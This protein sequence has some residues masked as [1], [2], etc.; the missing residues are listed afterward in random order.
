[1][2]TRIAVILAGLMAILPAVAQAYVGPGAGLTAIGSL[3]ALLA[4]VLLVVVGFVWYPL[5]RLMRRRKVAR[6]KREAEQA[7]K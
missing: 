4:A 5:K 7:E 2:R 3:L 1:M 6:S